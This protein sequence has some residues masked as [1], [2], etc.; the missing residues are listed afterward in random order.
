[1]TVH[2]RRFDDDMI[3]IEVTGAMPN[4]EHSEVVDPEMARDI[5][6][7]LLDL[8]DSQSSTG[9]GEPATGAIGGVSED[10]D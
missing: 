3:E 1:M 10:G 4:T 7:D 5:A 8:A 6:N 9:N 2:L